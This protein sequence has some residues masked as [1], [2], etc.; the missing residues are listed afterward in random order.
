MRRFLPVLLIGLGG[1]SLPAAG[2]FADNYRSPRYGA[3]SYYDPWAPPLEAVVWFDEYSGLASFEVNRPA[4]VAL[5]ALQPMGRIEMIYP[6]AGYGRARQYARGSHSVQTRASPYRFA[7]SWSLVSGAT[8]TYIVLIAS[9]RPLDVARFMALGS[10]PWLDRLAMISSPFTAMDELAR[11]IVPRASQTEWTLA[12]HV[13]WPQSLWTNSYY[14]RPY[15]W[16]V[17]PGRVVLSVPL[18]AVRYGWVYCPDGSRAG[19][20][21]DRDSRRLIETVPARPTAP[22]WPG[23]EDGLTRPL[24]ETVGGVPRR[25]G[26]PDETEGIQLPRRNGDPV[27]PSAPAA[28]FTETLPAR[29]VARPATPAPSTPAPTTTPARP[30]AE[31][32]TEGRPASRPD[33]ETPL[34]PRPTT[35]PSRPA[36]T[37]SRPEASPSRPEARPATPA[38]PTTRQ[39]TPTRPAAQ[40]A[41]PARPQARPSA[42]ARPAA[43][44]ATPTRPAAK[45]AT[46]ARPAA[47]P[48]TP[49]RPAAKPATPARPAAKPATPA[50]PAAKPAPTRPASRPAPK[51]AKPKGGG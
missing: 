20:P 19:D 14:R 1:C 15:T 45:P 6:A 37:P 47:R 10:S 25:P 41:A 50:R 7:S 30:G 12:Y 48:A 51:K 28:T 40:P 3:G 9:E 2:S 21:D 33:F 43:R 46:P 26:R 16:I 5:F 22:G 44:P 27:E 17:C 23:P 36:D 32:Q 34:R 8:P 11:E 4:Y 13:I 49:T 24:V 42:P 35:P 18:E 29:P 39:A 31:P 38:R